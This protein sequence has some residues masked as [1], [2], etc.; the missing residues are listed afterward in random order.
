M[1]PSPFDTKRPLRPVR[2]SSAVMDLQTVNRRQRTS[3]R[4]GEKTMSRDPFLHADPSTSDAMK[5]T[6]MSFDGKTLGGVLLG[7]PIYRWWERP[8]RLFGYRKRERIVASYWNNDDET[9]F[10]APKDD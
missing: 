6:P 5:L 10:P 3:N 2:A 8:L 1:K 4:T 7:P 9:I